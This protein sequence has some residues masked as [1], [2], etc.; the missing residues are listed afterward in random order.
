M[1]LA[2]LSLAGSLLYTQSP[3]S[4]HKPSHGLSLRPAVSH[5]S[6]VRTC[7]DRICSFGDQ[8][9]APPTSR[10]V[11]ERH[12]ASTGTRHQLTM[13]LPLRLQHPVTWDAPNLPVKRMRLGNRPHEADHGYRP[14][15]ADHG[16]RPYEADYDRVGNGPYETHPGHSPHESDYGP[17]NR[18]SSR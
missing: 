8:E 17:A 16:Y 3:R 9:T 4:S 7:A 15:E 14:Y 2:C 11:A 1:L 6:T 5:R 13:S 18:W 10:P 12:L